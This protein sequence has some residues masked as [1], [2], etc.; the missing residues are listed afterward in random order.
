MRCRTIGSIVTL[1]L[2]LLCAP[3]LTN[4]QQPGKVVRIGLLSLSA[5]SSLAIAGFRQRLRELEYVEGQNL[6]LVQHDA[7]GQY[8]RLPDLA[9]DLVGRGVEVLVAHGDAATRA[10][11][12]ATSTI[13]IV[14]MGADPI[15]SGGIASLARP[16]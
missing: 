8:G 6:A 11:Q 16:D 2:G 14:M 4:A 7:E 15:A 12:R 10:A 5:A 3:L 1:A 9:T 13:P